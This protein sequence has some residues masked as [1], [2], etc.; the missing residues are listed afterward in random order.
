MFWSA[1]AFNL[2]K[3][4]FK[5]SEHMFEF[6]VASDRGCGL[7]RARAHTASFRPTNL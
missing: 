7:S 3:P 5:V 1:A 4:F 6:R 2:S